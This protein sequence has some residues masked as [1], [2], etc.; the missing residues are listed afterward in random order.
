MAY[1]VV[2]SIF[3]FRRPSQPPPFSAE[4]WVA[5]L[6]DV[7]VLGGFLLALPRAE[8]AVLLAMLVVVV[9]QATTYP[10]AAAT[11]TASLEAVAF[12]AVLGSRGDLGR[13]GWLDVAA[14]AVVA[15]LT[16]VIVGRQ[17]LD[18]RR[19]ET[20]LEESNDT[21]RL[22][23]DLRTKL[24]S[25]LAH[26]VRNPLTG[27]R[28]GVV[29]LR[30]V[31]GLNDDDRAVLLEGIDRQSARLQR[32][33]LGLLDLARLEMGTLTL[34]LDVVSLVGVVEGAIGYADPD[35]RM[36][37]EVP[38]DLHARIDA[39]RMEQVIVNLVTNALAYG[40]DPVALCASR[41][42][43]SVT[44]DVSDA[45]PGV[46]D[47]VAERLFEPFGRGE[48]GS[49]VGLGLWIARMLAE[50]HGG[51]ITYQRLQPTGS[52]FRVMFP[53]AGPPQPMT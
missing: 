9:V 25:M 52:C 46:A 33:A 12:A 11:T 48:A 32:L 16:L 35:G 1:E 4:W 41:S 53:E 39:E 18:L 47:D 21:L 45:G 36:R 38:S 8:P 50:A 27:I 31:E 44:I 40:A 37:V 23:D 7:A 17:A 28:G 20:A 19:S 49:S 15:F 43:G 14:F 34:D 51:T 2:V 22:R 42:E 29:A 3:L 10:A 5:T 30:S 26:D 6:G 13:W 24:I